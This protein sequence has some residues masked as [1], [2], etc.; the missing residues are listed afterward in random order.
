MW[1]INAIVV[2]LLL[3][4][5]IFV[6]YFRSPIIAGLQPQRPIHLEAPAKR[7][8]LIV[9]DGLR[10]ESFFRNGCEDIPNLSKLILKTNGLVGISHTR[11]PTESR[12]GHIALIAG[13]YE[14]PSA[15]TRGWK[16]NP[17]DFDT[18]FNRSRHTYAWGAADV[19]HIFSRMGGIESEQRLLIDA[20]DHEL[21]FSGRD[22]TYELDDWVFKHVRQLLAR[23]RVELLEQKQIVFF[24]HL[25]G[26]DTAGHVHKPGSPNFLENLHRT[27]RGITELYEE[28]ERVFP[29]NRTAYVL[30]SDHGMTNAGSHGS[31]DAFETETPFF[32][33]GAGVTN[34]IS[35]ENKYKI[36]DDITRPRCNMQQAQIA[37]IMSALIG[38]APPM[39]NVG[40]LPLQ[41]LNA[42]PEYKAHA[43]HSNA[44]QLLAQ[45]Q[46]LLTTH[47]RGLFSGYL[48]S[49]NE[50]NEAVIAQYLV[51][52]EKYMRNGQYEDAINGSYNIMQLALKGI[53]YYQGYYRRP[54]QLSTTATF[55]C[56]IIYC[57]QLLLGHRQMVKHSQD[58]LTVTF[59]QKLSLLVVCVLLL[60]QRVPLVI[61]FYLLLPLLV[62][63]LLVQKQGISLLPLMRAMPVIQLLALVLCAELFV[64]SF[65]ERKLIS[66]SFLIY[67][68]FINLRAFP[69]NNVKFY[70]WLAL[71]LVLATFPLLPPTLGYTNTW[72]LLLG[73]CV[74]LLRP[75]AVKSHIHWH[76]KVPTL[77]CLINA[78]LVSYWHAQQSGVPFI[79]HALSWC[80]LLYI[81]ALITFH[82]TSVLKQRIELL[83]FL[84]TSLYTLLCTSYESLFIVMLSSEL[85]LTPA[86]QPIQLPLS[87]RLSDSQP[88]SRKG[89]PLAVNSPQELQAALKLSFTILLYT[90]FS[91]FGTGNIASVSSFDPNIVRCF[92]STFAP[93]LIMALVILKLVI[94]VVLNIT[95]IYGMSSFARANEQAIFICLLLI[96]DVMGL[97]FLFLVRNEGSWLEIGTSISHFVIMEVTTVVLVIFTYFAKLL[98]RL[99][100]K[101][102]N[103]E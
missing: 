101:V 9:T 32:L 53:E 71:S 34:D 8:V 87:R 3:L 41:Y 42:T 82:R 81:F 24:L 56:W 37:P 63:L 46:A 21:D 68:V 78:L 60:L 48:F 36:G 74:T 75:F 85:M 44:L 10:A 55:I 95:I 43:A 83:F 79:S 31:S 35:C 66:L 72:L 27:E 96:C 1:I 2:H 57:L 22:K 47:Q 7:L 89:Q 84:L 59:K 77:V 98:L 5:S 51:H 39:N 23:K 19:L 80:F 26:L 6:I 102:Q 103:V 70:I 17:V 94:P 38:I 100:E 13:L 14:D 58:R 30:T 33:W 88:Q 91:F 92:L 28:F 67:S 69:A 86:A 20:Y 50:L 52:S 93:F 97:N 4:G 90:L 15:V 29:D 12:P 64:Y 11:V 61:A 49:Y 73:M 54:L 45:F 62:W 99:N 25:L 18:V 16:R 40:I 76:I 65:F